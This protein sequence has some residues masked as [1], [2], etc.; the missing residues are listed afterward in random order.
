MQTSVLSAGGEIFLLDMGKPIKIYDLAK[1]MIIL[2]GLSIKDKEN[3]NG[4]IEIKITGL[5]EG[6]KLYE[7]LLV[8]DVSEK[9]IHPLIFKSNEKI[10]RKENFW[11]QIDFLIESLENQN[12]NNVLEIVYELVPEWKKPI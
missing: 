3:P 8:D 7:E 9:T 12:L 4:D 6:E 11:D 10:N 2:S 1:K 5:R